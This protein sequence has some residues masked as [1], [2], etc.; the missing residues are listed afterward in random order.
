VTRLAIF[1]LDGTLVDS[2]AD[3]ARA[4]NHARAALGLP[5]HELG[6][7]VGF[8]GDGAAKLI[9]R[10]TPEV[11]AADRA[12]ALAAFEAHYG[13]H[14]CV[15]TVVYPGIT[16]LLGA[17]RDAGWALAVA[18]NKPDAMTRTLLAGLGLARWFAG[19]R[20]GDGPR[21]PDPGQLTALMTA[22]G[23][24]PGATW[25]IGDHRTDIGAARAAGCRVAFCRWGFGQHDGL[26][27]DADVATP[28]ELLPVLLG[29]ATQQA[30]PP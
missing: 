24:A 3:I 13:A 23:V 6:T 29:R 19:V 8:V 16:A 10:M 20:G 17:L 25:M 1:D 4:A 26:A 28:G 14:C 22:A 5:A 2:R 21:K 7:V 30:T 12:R 11:G 9:E 27:V 15:D 18:T